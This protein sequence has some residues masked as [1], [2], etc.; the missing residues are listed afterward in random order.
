MWWV[1]VQVRQFLSSRSKKG[2]E[3]TA[4]NYLATSSFPFL[5]LHHGLIKLQII[6]QVHPVFSFSPAL[7]PSQAKLRN[8]TFPYI[9]AFFSQALPAFTILTND[10]TFL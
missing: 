7:L 6:L 2:L 10:I 9:S 5:F 3:S 8:N 4:P 1:G